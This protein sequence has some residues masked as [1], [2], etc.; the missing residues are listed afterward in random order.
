MVLGFND[1]ILDLIGNGSS[2]DSE[3][4]GSTIKY[5]NL[6]SRYSYNENSEN[7]FFNFDLNLFEL[8]KMNMFDTLNL[9]VYVNDETK[10]LSGL[11]VGLDIKVLLT[12]GLGAKLDLVDLG[13]EFTLD[14]MNSY[15]EQH[16]N[17]VINQTYTI[18]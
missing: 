1:T 3:S 16:Q 7:P 4:S 6:I 11:D 17:D 8:T 14:T 9:K 13:S 2:S 5:E 15:I 12:I 18:N 10:T